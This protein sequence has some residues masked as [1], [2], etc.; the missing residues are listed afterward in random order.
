[1]LKTTIFLLALVAI[2]AQA[3]VTIAA[4]KQGGGYDKAAQAIA[5]R[6]GQ[7]GISATVENLD[8]SDAITLAICG[9][10]ADLGLT[11]IDAVWA[12]AQEGCDLKAIGTYGTEVAVLLFPPKS[13]K[14]ELSDLRESDAVLADTIGSGSDLA[15][16]TMIR[17]ENGDH[18]SHDKWAG[19]RVVNDQLQLAQASAEMGDITAVFMVRKPT[20]PA[21]IRLLENGWSLGYLWDKNIDDLKFKDKPL[22]EATKLDL[23]A[24]GKHIRNWGYDVRS[25][26][27]AGKSVVNGPK[28]TFAAVVSAVAQ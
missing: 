7:R 6:L 22:Y 1:M 10:S 13:K 24:N 8:G 2:P 11:Q 21:I 27:V 25:L 26:I 18:G 17:I 5:Q 20:D 14:D 9:G 28:D 19:L 3:D 16:R 4:G 12:R 15:L 23:V